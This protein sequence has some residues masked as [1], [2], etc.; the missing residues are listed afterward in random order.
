[1]LRIDVPR[2]LFVHRSPGGYR[3][4]VGSGQREMAPDYLAR[5][6]QQRG[7]ARLIHF[8]E[9][10]VPDTTAADLDPVRN[11]ALSPVR[12]MSPKP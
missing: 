2:S 3:L 12:L 4:R 10:P 6:F 11:A 7:Q 8:D 5:L 9:Q 1:M